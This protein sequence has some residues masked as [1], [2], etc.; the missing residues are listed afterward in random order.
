M[1]FVIIDRPKYVWAYLSFSLPMRRFIWLSA[2]FS[3]LVNL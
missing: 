3:H 2:E 1:Y